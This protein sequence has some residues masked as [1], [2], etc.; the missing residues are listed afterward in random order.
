MA[1]LFSPDSDR[2][3]GDEGS[4]PKETPIRLVDP[5]AT[6]TRSRRPRLTWQAHPSGTRYRVSLYRLPGDEPLV[7]E[8]VVGRTHWQPAKELASDGTYAWE[9][10]AFVGQEEVALSPV[11]RFQVLSSA[12]TQQLS[13]AEQQARTPLARA[14]LYV[15]YGLVAEARK[16][17]QAQA[18]NPVARR[19]LEEIDPPQE[20]K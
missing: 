19:M 20:P 11:A 9:V 4:P 2:T 16:L 17:L 18:E 3:L 7:V 1:M 10:Q 5:V 15:Q 12:A 6:I 8:D 14:T 13:K